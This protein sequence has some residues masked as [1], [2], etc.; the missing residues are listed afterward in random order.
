MSFIVRSVVMMGMVSIVAAAAAACGGGGGTRDAPGG[1]DP[2][3]A[4]APVDGAADASMDAL[5]IGPV[6]VETRRL[7]CADGDGPAAGIVVV[8]VDPDGTARPPVTTDADGLARFEDVTRG[9]S[10]TATFPFGDGG[11]QIVTVAGVAP[12]DRLVMG[13]RGATPTVGAAGTMTVA[14]PPL[15]VPIEEVRAMHLCGID[16]AA[17]DASPVTVHFRDYCQR[18]DGEIWLAAIDN[19]E[20]LGTARIAGAYTPGAAAAVT[21]WT[22]P[23]TL[24]ANV[25]GLAA[26]ADAQWTLR[27]DSIVATGLNYQALGV[28]PGSS[29]EITVPADSDRLFG[30][31]YASRDGGNAGTQVYMVAAPSD[32]AVLDVAP[33]PLPWVVQTS[34]DFTEAVVSWSLDGTG[35]YDG[36]VVSLEFDRDLDGTPVYSRWVVMVPPG[37]TSWAWSELRAALGDA[38]PQSTDTASYSRLQVEQLPDVSGYDALRQ[39]P[40]WIY[41]CTI[42]AIY[43]GVYPGPAAMSIEPH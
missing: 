10:A 18:D 6:V 2:D 27:I 23:R 41:D 7:C 21:A 29:V 39:L 34:V 24:T 20:L 40:Q 31:L 14:F 19:F 25:T 11:A 8:L 28:G 4:G 30:H 3:A 32:A 35:D 33:P 17:G 16:S 43:D 22:P 37:T 38:I 12:G 26:D 42:C 15:A 13:D 1:P 5:T 9:A 36:T